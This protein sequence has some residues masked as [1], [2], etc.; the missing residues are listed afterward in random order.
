MDHPSKRTEACLV[1]HRPSGQQRWFVRMNPAHSARTRTC[2]PSVSGSELIEH[3]GET[4]T[5]GLLREGLLRQ[6]GLAEEKR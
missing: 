6:F 5:E 2:A 1:P 3:G 4:D